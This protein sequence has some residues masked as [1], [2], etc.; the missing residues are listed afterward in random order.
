[1]FLRLLSPHSH[2]GSGDD[3]S[4]VLFNVAIATIFAREFLEGAIIVGQYRTVIKRN[5][6]WDDDTKTR[7]LKTVT[8]SASGAALFAI[9]V[10]LAVAIP[11]GVFSKELDHKTVEII[12]GVS[13]VVA[14]VCILQLS[15]K[16][17]VWLGLYWKVSIFPWS[18]SYDFASL[19]L[20]FRCIWNN[21][22]TFGFFFSWSWLN[23]NSVID[24][25]HSHS[26]NNFILL[27]G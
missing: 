25:L 14:S 2:D 21:D 5:D 18:Y 8:Y 7:A 6:D 17:P 22:T 1:M 20:F 12:E 26:A 4:N 19:W 24:G 15:V 13:K 3:E 11:L 16:I 10:V 27:V 23:N 9:L